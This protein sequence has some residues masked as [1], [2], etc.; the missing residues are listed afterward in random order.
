MNHL[1]IY[2]HVNVDVICRTR[3]TPQLNATVEI[4]D[5]KVAYGGT[6]G[7]IAAV[8]ASLGCRTALASF[9]GHDFPD[10]YRQHLA[11]LGID[12][13]ELV[14]KPDYGTPTWWGFIDNDHHV[15]GILDQGP[16]RDL[17][18]MEPLTA[19]LDNAEAVHFA[20]GRPTYY[21]PIAKL[22]NERS[23][24]VHFDPGQELL[25]IYDAQ[26]LE[27]MLETAQ[28]FFCNHHEMEHALAKLGYGA[29]EQLFDHN[30]EAVIETRGAD[31]VVVH[32]DNGSHTIRAVPVPPEDV[33]DTT[34]AGDAFRAGYHAARQKGR[35]I[36]H[37][38]RLGLAAAAHC[39]QHKGG[40]ANL[41]DIDQLMPIVETLGT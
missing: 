27:A 32:R 31:G 12:L 13:S 33:I 20:T 16:L 3:D 2:G 41:P 36:D 4:T 15:L 11:A 14:T 29:A 10:A 24:P 35:D 5:R 6:G 34:G 22:C 39:I 25:P 7:N 17:D 8:A 23:I 19:G 37:R 40:Q 28:V 30:L 1:S 21:L 26:N 38:V 18:K 9:V